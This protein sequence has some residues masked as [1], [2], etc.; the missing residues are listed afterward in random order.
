M[1]WKNLIHKRRT[2]LSPVSLS[3]AANPTEAPEEIPTSSPSFLAGVLAVSNAHPHS[4]RYKPIIYFVIQR[5]RHKARTDTLNLVGTGSALGKHRR[6][7]RFNRNYF[8]IRVMT[9]EILANTGNSTSG[10]HASNKKIQSV[11]SQI[12]GA[13]VYAATVLAK[14]PENKGMIIVALLPD[15][16]D[17]LL[18]ICK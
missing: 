4:L 8:D 10:A 9:L 7:D 3:N 5:I 15:T 16:G 6:T 17:V 11:S 1:V 13:S 2:A 18:I 12:S 14:R